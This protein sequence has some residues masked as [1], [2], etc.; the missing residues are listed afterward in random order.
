MAAHC[1][2]IWRGIRGEEGQLGGN[3]DEDMEN[4]QV[5]GREDAPSDEEIEMAE[6]DNQEEGWEGVADD[7]I[8]L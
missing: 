2:D 3:G 8:I 1:T 6:G 4:E 5:A 7:D